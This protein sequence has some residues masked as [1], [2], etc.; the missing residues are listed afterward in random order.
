LDLDQAG[1]LARDVVRGL[2]GLGEKLVPPL[3][4]QPLL[5]IIAGKPILM[6]LAASFVAGCPPPSYRPTCPLGG[7]GYTGKR[8]S[9]STRSVSG[10]TAANSS[11]SFSMDGMTLP[12]SYRVQAVLDF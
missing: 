8:L 2:E 9:R 5:D 12:F 7:G 10:E 6:V 3:R 4:A 11:A 1:P